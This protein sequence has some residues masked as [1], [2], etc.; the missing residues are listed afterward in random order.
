MVIII[1]II[2]QIINDICEA[3]FLRC[4]GILMKWAVE[5]STAK[6]VA[7]FFREHLG[8]AHKSASL[9]PA[10]GSS[11]YKNVADCLEQCLLTWK[12]SMSSAIMIINTHSI[13]M[14]H[15]LQNFH[16]D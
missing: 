16:E 6:W 10:S 14:V 15:I 13:I 3:L 8:D 11:L 5:T 9:I 4:K 7:R 12:C 2:I 1:I